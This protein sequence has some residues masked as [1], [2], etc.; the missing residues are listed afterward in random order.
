MNGKMRFMAFGTAV[1]GYIFAVA[2]YVSFPQNHQTAGICFA[3]F[4][5]I[6]GTIALL[7]CIVGKNFFQTE[8]KA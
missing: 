3:S 4:F 7:Q 8:V 2:S 1:I 5:G 6:L